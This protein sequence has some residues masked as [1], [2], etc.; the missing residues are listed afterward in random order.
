MKARC[1]TLKWLIL[2]GTLCWLLFFFKLFPVFVNID[3]SM[4]LF[5]TASTKTWA[6]P[7]C[8]LQRKQVFALDNAEGPMRRWGVAP[9]KGGGSSR[10]WSQLICSAGPPSLAVTVRISEVMLTLIVAEV[11][12]AIGEELRWV[13]SWDESDKVMLRAILS[14]DPEINCQQ[15]Y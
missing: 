9:E 11:R 4:R 8:W 12:G 3:Y 14:I 1:R 5:E 13:L 10:N 7:E 6:Y 2:G 15:V